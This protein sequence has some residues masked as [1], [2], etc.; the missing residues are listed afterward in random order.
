MNVGRTLVPR[1]PSVIKTSKLLQN[2]AKHFILVAIFTD[3]V[4]AYINA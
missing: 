3:I 1:L 2:R 4:S